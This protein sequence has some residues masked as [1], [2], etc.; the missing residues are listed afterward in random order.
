MSIDETI[1]SLLADAAPVRKMRPGLG[2][3]QV[4]LA[5]AG[6]AGIVALWPGWRADVLAGAPAP[7]VLG[8][9]AILLLATVVLVLAALRQGAPGMPW[10]GS[11]ATGIAVLIA[12]PLIAL[13]VQDA[14]GTSTALRARAMAEFANAPHCLLVALLAALPVGLALCRWLQR[15]GAVTDPP[16]AGW[17]VGLAAGTAGTLAYSV[18]CPSQHWL[19][20][21]LVYPLAIVLAALTGRAALP[22]LLRW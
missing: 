6:S 17:I 22:A 15:E 9:V 7:V 11:A 5:T 19:F 2:L 21:G 14:P 20:A 16:T 13:A 3:A 12:L 8:R 1:E 4:A 18:T 10:R